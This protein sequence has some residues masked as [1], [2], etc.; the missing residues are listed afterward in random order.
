VTDD[1]TGSLADDDEKEDLYWLSPGM[2]PEPYWDFNL[3]ED[4]S[5]GNNLLINL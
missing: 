3:C 2:L 4:V 1:E 5:R